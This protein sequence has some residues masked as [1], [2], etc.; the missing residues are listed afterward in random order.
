MYEVVNEDYPRLETYLC[1]NCGFHA[2]TVMMQQ[3]SIYQAYQ[4]LFLHSKGLLVPKRL[5]PTKLQQPK[6]TP[7]EDNTTNL[8]VVLHQLI[9][10]GQDSS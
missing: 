7:D 2:D 1:Y 9:K 5:P 8:L 6:K 4:Q 10:R 3:R